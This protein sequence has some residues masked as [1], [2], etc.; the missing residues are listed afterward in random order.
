MTETAAERLPVVSRADVLAIRR[1]AKAHALALGFGAAAVAEV[2]TAIAELATNLVK[3]AIGGGEVIIL[4]LTE[5]GEPGLEI[6]VRDQ[7][8]GIANL[9]QAMAGGHS[10]SGTLG[11]GLSG[12]KRLMDEFAIQT[13]AG[14]GTE[15]TVRKWRERQKS[16]ILKFSVLACPYPGETVSGDGYFIKRC[17]DYEVFAVIDVL[18]HGTDAHDVTGK[19]LELLEAHWQDDLAAI[20]AA[21]HRGLDH[22]RGAAMALGRVDRDGSRLEHIS[23]GNVATRIYNTSQPARPYCFNGTLGMAMERSARPESYPLGKDALIVMCSDGIVSKFTVPDHLAN[24]GPQVIAESIFSNYVRGSD[25]AT[26]LVAK[27]M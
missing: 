24:D 12:V 23:I 9:E 21:C 2:E 5:G 10:T 11:I 13:G 26:V 22:T 3:H 6:R 25:D 15:I 17:R 19:C 27:V 8:P 16:A 14:A 4:P 1:I 7:G 20:I 18:G